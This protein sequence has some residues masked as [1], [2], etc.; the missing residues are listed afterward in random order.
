[1]VGVGTPVVLQGVESHVGPHTAMVHVAQERAVRQVGDVSATAV[2]SNHSVD[3][4]DTAWFDDVLPSGGSERK[5]WLQQTDVA[6]NGYRTWWCPGHFHATFGTWNLLGAAL[7]IGVVA[8]SGVSLQ[9]YRITLPFLVMLTFSVALSGL[10]F[11]DGQAGSGLVTL[12]QEG[13]T[14]SSHSIKFC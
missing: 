6:Q 3:A 14:R 9:Q 2:A 10:R 5:T 7:V 8:T 13:C 4:P 1:M 12:G 11:G